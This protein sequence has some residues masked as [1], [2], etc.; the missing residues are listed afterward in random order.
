[1]KKFILAITLSG[2]LGLSS[3]AA[4]LTPQ[5]AL[6]RA[7][8]DAPAKIKTTASSAYPALAF[9]TFSNAQPAIYMFTRGSESGFIA[10]SAD[11]STAPLL[12]YSTHGTLPTSFQSLPD[13]MQYWLNSLGEQIRYNAI[14]ASSVKAQKNAR[15]AV[16]REQIMP[17]TETRW[18]QD[19]PYN[20]D[21]PEIGTSRCYTGCVATA[22]AQVMKYYEWPAQGVGSHSYTWSYSQGGSKQSKTLSLDYSTISYDWSKMADIYNS[23]TP[24]EEKAEVAKLMY[25]C[26]VAVN[27]EYGTSASGAV[28]FDMVRALIE[29]FDYNKG[30]RFL[31]R[32]YYGINDWETIIYENL[33]D[34]G[35]V[36]YGGQSNTGGHQFVCDGYL[37]GYFHFN[38]GWGGMSD[39]YF[40]L[41][42][43]DP[44]SQGI[45][46]STSGYNFDQ[47]ILTR[48]STSKENDVPYEQILWSG[49]FTI[50]NDTAVRGDRI[51]FTGNFYNYSYGKI[52]GSLG[53][54]FI[55]SDG[56]APTF[57]AASDLHSLSP[58]SG[59]H[60][61]WGVNLPDSLA[62]GRYKVVPAMINS[63]GVLQEVPVPLANRGSYTM[64]LSG[65]TATFYATA[66]ASISVSDFTLDSE[67][68][69]GQDFKVSARI[70][71][72]SAT[73]EFLGDVVIGM[74]DENGSLAARGAKMSIDLLPNEEIEWD[75]V[76]D[77][78]SNISG[79]S[80]TPGSYELY[81]YEIVN[82]YAE[83]VAGPIS[84]ELHA[85]S[86]PTL[87]ASNLI[88]ADD[89]P[90]DNMKA[91]ADLDCTSGYFAGTVTLYIFPA[92]GGR[93]MASYDSEFITLSADEAEASPTLRT[94]TGTLPITFNFSF[95]NAEPNT[96]YEA[97][98]Y[99]NGSWI[100]NI[101]KFRT[102]LETGVAGAGADE[103]QSDVTSR[104]YYSLTGINLGKET[105]GKGIYIVREQHRNGH[106]SARRVAV[107]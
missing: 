35:P 72:N 6:Q 13:G 20:N 80:L 106:I 61:T 11:D 87:K 92:S 55:P 84:V 68:Y 85:A 57:L 38:W 12:G 27:M 34:Y 43:L 36:L 37:D 76:S 10:V 96:E 104:Q 73:E 78:A 95:T 31:V 15:A 88:I 93:S 3:I 70:Q 53:L 49:D 101:V 90:L 79:S 97:G 5:E 8:G 24:E 98:I 42:A 39:G 18:N 81:L 30:M 83:P 46:G 16:A 56:D 62:D 44:E 32:D 9:T 74:V 69:I 14:H 89:Q 4:I 7:L 1:M 29:N 54:E 77:L 22:M 2:I 45:G 33:R 66:P 82:G 50:N 65:D 41:T 91:T 103:S 75:Y 63:Q 71:N 19:A 48:I 17:M 94:S 23:S 86:T 58:G 26:G 47:D 40:L 99:H 52:N 59:L 102:G 67:L 21:C 51:T 64:V 28:S 60:V 25:S 107:K 100:S 105:P